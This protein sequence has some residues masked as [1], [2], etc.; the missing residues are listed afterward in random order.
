MKQ[1]RGS[2]RYPGCDT[3]QT[4]RTFL[5]SGL[6]SAGV[7]S[8]AL[9]ESWTDDPTKRT[10]LP[11]AGVATVYRRNSHADVILGKVLEGY[12]QDGGPGPDLELVSLYV[13]QFPDE[14]MSR[15][16]AEE[17]GFRLAK[18]IDEAI[19][20]GGDKVAVAG[21][22]SIGEHGS[23]PKV[24]ATGQVMYP[25]KRFFDEIVGALKRGGKVVPVF[26]DKHLSYRTDYALDMHRTAKERGIAFLAGSSLPVA[27]RIPALELPMG[28][29]IETA[30]GIGYSEPESYGFHAI[31][32]L[33]CMVER[34][35]GGE[36][37][38]EAV[39][40][41]TGAAVLEAEDQGYWS[42]DLL[43][44]ALEV[45]SVEL[46]EDW[47]KQIT[48]KDRPFFLIDYRDG[49]KA[50]V[51]M[52]EGMVGYF[53]FAAKLKGQ[54]EPTATKFALQEGPPHRH[55]EWLVKAIEHMVHSGVPPYPV[56][57]TVLTTGIVD[58]GMHSL[59]DEGMRIETPQLDIAYR[60]ARW[61]HA[62]DR[63]PKPREG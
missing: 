22:L 15:Q 58:A 27:W 13:D 36:T 4:R 24:E 1:N 8:F 6:A 16:L 31:E 32:M 34:R 44:A 10:K 55:F 9:S 21:V 41:A 18:T 56:E 61:P 48:E 2:N 25:R 3:S 11:V 43:A 49:L 26:N 45:Q 33:Q 57:R 54:K 42:Q 14:D 39:R 37:G 47:R 7:L 20:L 40:A 17:H 5:K 60:A 19:T 35:G 38:V 59:A 12:N 46:P 52:L 29:E 53:S 51:A 50:S 63:P 30:M 28:C 23:Y 62:P